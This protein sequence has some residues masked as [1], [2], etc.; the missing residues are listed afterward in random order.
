MSV[1]VLTVLL[2]V[3]AA[4][5]DARALVTTDQARRPRVDHSAILAGYSIPISRPSASVTPS[6]HDQLTTAIVIV[7]PRICGPV[8]YRCGLTLVCFNLPILSLVASRLDCLLL[9]S[10]LYASRRHQ[11]S[12]S[13]LLDPQIGSMEH[14]TKADTCVRNRNWL[15]RHV[16]LVHGLSVPALGALLNAVRP[17]QHVNFDPSTR[18]SY[19]TN[20]FMHVS[21]RG[22]RLDARPV[23]IVYFSNHVILVLYNVSQWNSLTSEQC[24][25]ATHVE[26]SLNTFYDLL[27][28]AWQ[29]LERNLPT[30][31]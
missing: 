13:S 27:D 21:S 4:L 20:G 10:V 31:E 15:L 23:C 12:S 6:N 5:G 7:I 29:C 11:A 18:L 30:P 14:G 26:T 19:F 22:R 25:I 17:A 16:F 2:F 1:G 28:W 24:I 9:G 8:R 3:L